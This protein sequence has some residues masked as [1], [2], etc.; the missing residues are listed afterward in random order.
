MQG[1]KRTPIRSQAKKRGRSQGSRQGC[2]GR[3]RAPWPPARPGARP[4]PEMQEVEA[5]AEG[6]DRPEPEPAA[7]RAATTGAIMLAE[8]A[9]AVEALRAAVD[10]CQPTPTHVVELSE[11]DV[12][13]PVWPAQARNASDT[14]DVPTTEEEGVTGTEPE[15]AEEAEEEAAE[16]GTTE[17]E[18]PTRRSE[19]CPSC[20]EVLS[21]GSWR[22]CVRC[23]A[24]RRIGCLARCSRG[25]AACGKR[26]CAGCEPE[27]QHRQVTRVRLTGEEETLV[28]GAA[29]V[30][31]RAARAFDELSER[32]QVEAARSKAGPAERELW[33]TA[34]IRSTPAMRA[35]LHMGAAAVRDVVRGY[36]EVVGGEPTRVDPDAAVAVAKLEELRER[37]K[38]RRLYQLD[39]EQ[40]HRSPAFYAALQKIKA[41]ESR[42]TVWQ[43]LRRERQWRL[44]R[45]ALGPS[46][47][48]RGSGGC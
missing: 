14:E 42:E 41:G 45:A 46:A 1:H 23:W 31:E 24:R 18:A 34:A 33:R 44:K 43:L 38:M 39:P 12:D 29:E 17:E 16:E 36:E 40:K 10:V 35:V 19:L 11:S 48:M 6:A 15:E 32:S 26:F 27:H 47:G 22:N 13:V 25:D 3:L 8:R 7:A 5:A 2:R 28:A 20:H 9:R 30:A 21:P 4:G 37:I